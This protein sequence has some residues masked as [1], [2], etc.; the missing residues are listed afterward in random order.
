MNE[1]GLTMGQAAYEHALRS[2]DAQEFELLDRKWIQLSGVLGGEYN[3][4]TGLFASALPYDG[5]RSMLEMGCGCGVA[6]V[7]GALEGV[8]R[9]TALDINPA[10]VRTTQLNAERHGVADRV[11]ARVSDLFAAVD[12]DAYDL[13]FWNSPFIQVPPDQLLDSDL[14]YH[15]FD[16]G[17]A[18]H[19]RFFRGA[20][21]RLSPSGR[22]F[23]GFSFAMGSSDRL[24]EV[25][26]AAGFGVRV[27][28]QESFGVSPEELGT[29]PVYADH[30]G[31]DA[32]VH[33]DFT[34]LELT[35]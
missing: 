23:L 6:S 32:R 35:R 11:T 17:Y 16:P 5:V 34:L 2:N 33:I 21:R 14:A 3:Y 22:L 25:V 4:A 9:V 13:I 19:E 29:S 12:D 27:H 15:F 7:I 8:P 31:D 26:T 30:A 20:R 24:R 10:A 28:V 1:L 18:M